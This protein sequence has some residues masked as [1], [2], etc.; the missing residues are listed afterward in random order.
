MKRKIYVCPEV[1]V[2]R[3]IMRSKEPK[4]EDASSSTQK[5][6]SFV[7][8]TNSNNRSSK[9][10]IRDMMAKIK[11]F[12]ANALTGSQK[13]NYK[14]DILTKLGAPPPKQPTMPFKIKMGILAGRKK[15]ELLKE[16]ELKESGVVLASSK[17]S[18][19]N[20]RV[21]HSSKKSK[22]PKKK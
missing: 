9:E 15:K 18:S 3:D 11:V 10:E 13:K 5:R 20:S 17:H 6:S 8:S 12:N 14:D 21:K 16:K 1:S 4:Y 22:K 19:S 2:P 7:G